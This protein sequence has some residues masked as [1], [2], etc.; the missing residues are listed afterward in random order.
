MGEMA[1]LLGGVVSEL[2]HRAAL[3]SPAER[4]EADDTALATVL[5]DDE[6]LRCAREQAHDAGEMALL[7]RHTDACIAFGERMMALVASKLSTLQ[8]VFEE[9]RDLQTVNAANLKAATEALDR[10]KER[11]EALKALCVEDLRK[12]HLLRRSVEDT[13]RKVAAVV[14]AQAAENDK[15]L[16][17]NASETSRVFSEMERLEKELERLEKERWGLLK[18]RVED[19]EK[20][21]H[22]QN[23]FGH[24]VAVCDAHT[25]ALNNTHRNAD[26]HVTGL[27]IVFDAAKTLAESVAAGHL[28]DLEAATEDTLESHKMH[29]HVFDRMWSMTSDQVAHRNAKRQELL[30][31]IQAATIQ[32]KL[33][34]ET[35]NP[36]A[37]RFAQTVQQLTAERADL[38]EEVRSLEQRGAAA[39]EQFD[40][41]SVGPLTAAGV[42]FVHP[43]DAQEA[44]Q[45]EHRARMVEYR[46]LTQLGTLDARPLAAEL[47]DIRAALATH[48]GRAGTAASYSGGVTSLPPAM[49]TAP[50]GTVAASQR[51]GSSSS[52]SQQVRLPAV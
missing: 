25:A 9:V 11:C 22:R 26:T 47:D 15:Q 44:R 14:E 16:A 38:E 31:Q 2:G 5:A 21:E 41:L 49:H 19:K 43:V 23:E 36:A 51:P 24:F 33:A 17:S 46:A 45:L 32:Q 13:E 28:A 4:T 42:S 35:Y 7:E 1:S 12:V 50:P 10:G 34:I 18:K 37:K 40:A 8:G 3:E 20:D 29:R 39:R 48:P 6:T 52:T 30:A 27:G